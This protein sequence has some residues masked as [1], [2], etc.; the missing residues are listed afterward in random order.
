M[1]FFIFLAKMEEEGGY[2]TSD[3]EPDSDWEVDE[4][5]QEAEL[6]VW[7]EQLQSF[8]QVHLIFN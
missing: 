6:G 7:L 1:T 8:Q 5:D 2:L 3:A 4:A